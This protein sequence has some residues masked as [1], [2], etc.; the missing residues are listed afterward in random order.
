MGVLLMLLIVV[1]GPTELAVGAVW[2]WGSV[3][4]FSSSV[5]S[6]FCR[7]FDR[8]REPLHPKQ[9]NNQISLLFHQMIMLYI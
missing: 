7:Q 6:L 8:D 1:Q 5:I 4:F 3:D 9:P 2:A